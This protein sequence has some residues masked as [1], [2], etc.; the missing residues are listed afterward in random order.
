MNKNYIN[1]KKAIA[2]DSNKLYLNIVF[3]CFA[4]VS[5]V[6]FLKE[7]IGRKKISDH[8]KTTYIQ[9]YTGKSAYKTNKKC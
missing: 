3:I 7:N 9:F 1:K 2:I 4:V 8:H 5:L 6:R